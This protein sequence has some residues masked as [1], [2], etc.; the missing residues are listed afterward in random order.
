MK[1][2]A[3]GLVLLAA[4]LTAAASDL[5]ITGSNVFG[6]DLG[7]RLVKAF[8]RANPDIMVALRRPG[9]GAGLE[10]LLAGSADLAPASRLPDRTE[11]RAARAAGVVIV[12]HPLAS[13]AVRIVVHESNPVRNLTASQ[14]S[15]IFAG[16]ITNWKKV[17]GPDMPIRL[18]VL[19]P[20]TGAR[21]GFRE[22]AMAGRPYADTAMSLPDYRDIAFRVSVDV[23][24]IGYTGLGPLPERVVGLSV[25]GVTPTPATIRD[26]TY[27]FVRPLW[28]CTLQ[29]RESAE[30][31]RFLDFV[32][33]PS[34]RRTIARAGYVPGE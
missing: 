6:E 18:F 33:S 21:A 16:R 10:A 5:R 11:Q 26:R 13:Y 29:G 23:A 9:T 2:L 25:G 1:T 15:R 8:T 30:A 19:G 4:A 34:A 28:L 7:P 31:R 3:A 22:V 14:V 32:S 17:G 20:H 12:P 27:P 24:G